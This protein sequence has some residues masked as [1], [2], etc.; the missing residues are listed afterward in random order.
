MSEQE[1]SP[2]RLLRARRFGPFFLTQALGAFNDNIFRNAMLLLVTF[3]VAELS[4]E[5]SNL[6]VN[7]AAGL[8][9]L[10]FFLFSATAGPIAEKYEKARLIRGIKLLEIAIM[11]VAVIGL[12]ARDV[13]MLLFVLFLMGAQSALFGPV[14][15]SICS[16]RGV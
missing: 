4:Q 9:I 14:K 13:T 16:P 1:Q 11:G 15:Y 5:Q 6:Y 7:L 10:P 2:F 3:R 8:F 12:L